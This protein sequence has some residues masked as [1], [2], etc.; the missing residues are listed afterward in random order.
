[1]NKLVEVSEEL[2]VTIDDI[3]IEVTTKIR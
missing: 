1:M 2:E 3:V